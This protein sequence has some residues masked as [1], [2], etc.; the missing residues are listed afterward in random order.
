MYLHLSRYA[1]GIKNGKQ[2]HQGEVIGYVGSSGLSTGPHIDYRF[3]VNGH[4]V[5]SLKVEVPPSHPVKES[6]RTSYET[7]KDSVVKRLNE[8][9]IITSE[10]PV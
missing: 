2:V 7:Q 10:K 1:K 5:D 3:F 6:L 8:I 9:I 4:P